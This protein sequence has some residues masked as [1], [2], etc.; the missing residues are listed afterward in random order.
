MISWVR[1]FWRDSVN[2][3]A[4]KGDRYRKVNQKKYA[5]NWEKAFGKKKKDSKNG[6]SRNKN[7]RTKKRS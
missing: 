2:D 4:G 1:G 6:I 5:E 3:K 7:S